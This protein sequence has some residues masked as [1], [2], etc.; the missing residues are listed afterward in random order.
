MAKKKAAR[1]AKKTQMVDLELDLD[2]DTYLFLVRVSK[3]SRCSLSQVVSVILA[4]SALAQS[5]SSQ[6]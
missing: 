5:E 4:S 2:L 6:K 3:L 1:K